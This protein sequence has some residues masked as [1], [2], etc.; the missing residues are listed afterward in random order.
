QTPSIG[1]LTFPIIRDVVSEVVQVSEEEIAGAVR[2]LHQE[3]GLTVEPSGAVTVAALLSGR[4]TV[5]GPVAAIVSGGNVDP[6]VF[7]RL[8]Q[9]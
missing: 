8:V 7:Q 9:G 6:A 1:A 2:A 5:V 4:V 3:M